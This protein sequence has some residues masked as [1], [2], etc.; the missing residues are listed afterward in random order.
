MDQTGRDPNNRWNDSNRTGLIM[1]ARQPINTWWFGLINEN[2]RLPVV[3]GS[4]S[5]EVAKT[6]DNDLEIDSAL[7]SADSETEKR[8]HPTGYNQSAGRC[9][10]LHLGH[11]NEMSVCESEK[12]LGHPIFLGSRCIGLLV[13]LS[14]VKL[15]KIHPFQIARMHYQ[16]LIFSYWH[17]SV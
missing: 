17:D 6:D 9:L 7:W 12:P 2:L 4:S 10:D 11:S 8:R 3:F 14:T 13:Y 15:V 16:I 1:Q 5:L